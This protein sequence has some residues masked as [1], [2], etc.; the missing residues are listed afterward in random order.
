M[1]GYEIVGKIL[2]QTNNDVGPLIKLTGGIETDWL[3]FKAATLPKGGIYKGNENKWDYRL[4]VSKAL[5]AMANSIGGAVLIG[6]G[7][8]NN[9]EV[10]PVSLECSGFEGNKDKFMLDLGGH[11][12]HPQHAWNTGTE[13]VWKCTEPHDLFRPIWGVFNEQPIII[14]LVKPR[15]NEDKWLQFECSDNKSSRNVVF[16]RRLGDRGQNNKR[17]DSDLQIWWENREIDRPDLDKRYQTFLDGWKR[18]DKHPE[19]VITGVVQSYLDAFKTQYKRDRLDIFFIP[20]NAKKLSKT[21]NE[22]S[23]TQTIDILE[24]LEKNSRIVLLGDP[25]S[26]KS[27]CLYHKAFIDAENWQPSRPWTLLIPL[28]EYTEL[29]LR[30]LLLKQLPSLYWIDIEARINSGE[31]TLMF[32]GLNECPA[33]YYEDCYQE[34]SGLLK[35]YPTA[36]VV[37][38]SRLSHTPDFDLFTFNICSMDRKQ[39]QLFLG[40]YLNNIER[41]TELIQR[42]Y[43]QPG[44]E[45]IAS[46]PVLLK[47][48]ADVGGDG[49][50]LPTSLAKLY[51]R[52]LEIWHQRESD[53]N[54]KNGSSPLWPFSRILDALAELSF[55]MRA[56][57]KVSCSISFAR[58]KLKEVLGDDV[59]R[60]IDR[61]AQGL[62]LIKDDK[63][64]F[65]HFSHE[66][67]Q[68]Y[69]AAEYLVKH[70][71]ALT[72]DLLQDSSG[73][74]TNNWSMPL[75]F[76]FELIPNPS[77]EFLQSAWVIEPMLVTAALRDSR[78]LASMPIFKHEDLWLRGVLRVM[79]GEDATAETLELAY[80]S[81][82]PPKYPLPNI[83]VASLRGTPFWYSAK[84][85]EEG[86][87]RLERLQCLIFDSSSMWIE[88][89]TYLGAGLSNR[90]K[91]ISP[92]QRV[93]IGEIRGKDIKSAIECATVAELCT[94]LRNKKI[95]KSDFISHWEEALQRS[96]ET[97]LRMDLIALLRTNAK[98][99]KDYIKLSE[100]NSEQKAYLY[101]IGKN[102]KLSLR[103][104]NILVR[105]RILTVKDIRDEPG[106]LEDIIKC[107]SP[108]NAF[109]FMK[110]GIIKQK[111]I[112]VNRLREIL[113]KMG[114]KFVTE[115]RDKGL[116]TSQE[117]LTSRRNKKY[118]ISDLNTK[119]SREKIDGE[120]NHRQWDVTILK[121]F[122]ERNFGFVRAPSFEG[123]V[124]FWLDK[125]DNPD[126]K[127]LLQGDKLR[128]G[129]KIQFNNK[130]SE[131]GFA[132]ISGR[133]LEK[134]SGST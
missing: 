50:D 93:L 130:K 84:T 60:F 6:V 53:K 59:V 82:L 22:N 54:K 51:H 3:E 120:I 8:K 13:G 133:I 20:L 27:T 37:I 87:A 76:A 81:H 119:E 41:S 72:E 90:K 124:I 56:E 74:R 106:R 117:A 100:F 63:D 122:S 105:E 69:L 49:G 92:A 30:S 75:V 107:M 103:L 2:G 80:I 44:A 108:M 101:E 5:F 61:I 48:V 126:N 33:V 28:Y 77:K 66:T 46:S 73:K 23:A 104:L 79:R 17:L 131:W 114:S 26:G 64:E 65:L 18:S 128:V 52:F 32:D 121:I 88:L 14:V 40:T 102:W 45:L 67:I 38:S 86:L 127:T 12:L 78:R 91:D 19:V 39:Q 96:D 113:E 43:R 111:D 55:H 110:N 15:K 34:I 95:S 109:R 97:Q 85:H 9:H 57:G 35:E 29:G 31:I 47:M 129:V 25:G 123:G 112:P 99:G 36:R 11:I 1:N 125:I 7:E 58:E 134:Y 4:D 16:S 21:V 115:L 70:Q 89:V 68:E 62:L 42:L 116:L 71:D 98:L 24:L 10:E 83:L 132:V 94:L 118:L